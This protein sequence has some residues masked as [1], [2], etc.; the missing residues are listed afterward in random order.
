MIYIIFD[1]IHNQILGASLD[2]ETAKLLRD[3][4]RMSLGKHSQIAMI[5]AEQDKLYIS[6]KLVD[7][8]ELSKVREPYTA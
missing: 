8:H 1:Y 4:A 7:L 5:F 6:Q 3:E 2:I